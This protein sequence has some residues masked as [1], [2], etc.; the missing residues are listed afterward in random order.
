M[1][2]H[3]LH[4]A[5]AASAAA[6]VPG[7]GAVVIPAQS[8]M[9]QAA[10]GMKFPSAL[11]PRL[12]GL[13]RAAEFEASMARCNVAFVRSWLRYVAGLLLLGGVAVVVVMTVMAVTDAEF[14]DRLIPGYCCGAGL[15]IIAVMGGVQLEK[16]RMGRIRKAVAAENAYY[17]GEQRAARFGPLRVP[18][19]WTAVSGPMQNGQ[20][21]IQGRPIIVP[22]IHIH[23]EGGT[24]GAAAQPQSPPQPLVA[25]PPFAQPAAYG[26][27]PPFAGHYPQPP[28]AQPSY[29]HP[30]FASTY[31]SISA[32]PVQAPSYA[33]EGQAPPA[34]SSHAQADA[35]SAT[36]EFAQQLQSGQSS[37]AADAWTAEGQPFKE[38]AVASPPLAQQSLPHSTGAGS[39]E[40]CGHAAHTPADRFCAACGGHI[41]GG[42]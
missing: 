37:A 19:S 24:I 31:A 42:S 36:G 8:I 33:Q 25:G 12:N 39:C 16:R 10:D 38:H 13:I 3:T 17:N 18:I 4:V 26:A 34:Y 28:S 41:V 6:P 40:R 35:L 23:I 2:A 9:L 27:P 22:G 5:M 1:A 7:S 29:A 20:T 14:T 15:M 30:T 21:D 11:P 32:Q